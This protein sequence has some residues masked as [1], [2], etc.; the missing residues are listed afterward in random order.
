MPVNFDEYKKSRPE[1]TE[2]PIDP[3]S[4]AFKILVFLAEHPGLGYKPDEIYENVD[5]AKGSLNP[6]LSRLEEQGLVEHESPYWSITEED[7][8]LMAIAGTMYS[9]EAFEQR[10]GDDDISEWYGTGVDPREK[11]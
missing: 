2:L 1:D 11:R 5:V 9:M 6:T 10:F 3:E 7:D 8:R 4:N